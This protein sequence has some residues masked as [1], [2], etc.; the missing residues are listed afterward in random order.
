MGEQDVRERSQA[1]DIRVF[2]K[3]L[4]KD[5]RAFEKMLEEDLFESGVR[6]IGAEQELFLV[7]HHWRPAPIATEILELLDDS[8][9]TTE[10]ARFNLEF[11]LDPLT[12]GG[13]C[14]RDMEWQVGEFLGRVISSSTT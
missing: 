7:D 2:L 11:N 13:S 9:F 1:E 10:L 12:F 14:L 4:L 3:D 6:R 8:H 5:V